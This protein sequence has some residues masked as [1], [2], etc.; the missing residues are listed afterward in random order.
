MGSNGRARLVLVQP[1][2]D[3]ALAHP[4]QSLRTPPPGPDPELAL[5][6]ADD[7][8]F[9]RVAQDLRRL[10]ME[11]EGMRSSLCETIASLA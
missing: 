4:G 10:A 7:L 2:H 8:R 9:V 1:R 6:D 11:R 3:D 5:V